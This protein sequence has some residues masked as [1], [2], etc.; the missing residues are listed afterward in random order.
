MA[1]PR[2]FYRERL[3]DE[4][5]IAAEDVVADWRELAARPR[6]ADGVIIATQDAQHADP[7][8]AFAE[9]GYHMLLEKPMAPS[10]GRVPP[11]HR[12][13]RARQQSCSRCAT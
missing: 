11:D 10:R 12:G 6:F 4:H 9:L 5:D 1:E 7:A 8:V 3:A 13:G 2:P